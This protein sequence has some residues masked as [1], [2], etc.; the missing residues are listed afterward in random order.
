V[1]T[2]SFHEAETV[3]GCRKNDKRSQEMLYRHFAGKMYA[4]SLNYAGERPM[5]QDI[6]QESFIKI[7]NSIKHY[8]ND[9]SLEGWIRRIVVNTAIDHIRKTKR[10]ERFLEVEPG[11]PTI[12]AENSAMK[13]LAFKEIMEQIGRLPEGARLIFNMHVVEGFSHKEIA[14]ELQI[15]EGTSKS[16]VN[17]ARQ[18]L[19]EFIGNMNL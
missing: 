16:Q 6:L 18:L 1:K 8:R 15:S 7:F 9:G 3:A 11:E 12:H 14:E 13:E 17:R 2:T 19:M 10:L 4:I 5:A